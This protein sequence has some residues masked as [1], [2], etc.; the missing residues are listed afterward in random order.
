MKPGR[1]LFQLL[2]G[3]FVLRKNALD[4]RPEFCRV[5]HFLEMGQFMRGHVIDDMRRRLDEFPVEPYLAF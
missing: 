4:H 3:F 2:L 5:V 1:E